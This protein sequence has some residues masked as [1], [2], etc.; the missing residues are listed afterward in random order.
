LRFRHGTQALEMHRRFLPSSL[1]PSFLLLRAFFA[2][3]LGALCSMTG[4]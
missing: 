1:S 2:G 3:V 4:R